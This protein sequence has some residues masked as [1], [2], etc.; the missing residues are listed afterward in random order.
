MHGQVLDTPNARWSDLDPGSNHVTSRASSSKDQDP[1]TVVL[2]SISRNKKEI[3]S[4]V[5]RTER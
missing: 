2:A 5:K 1:H 4:S 3:A